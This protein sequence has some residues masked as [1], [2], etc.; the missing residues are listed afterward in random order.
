MQPD[1]TQNS[2]DFDNF[3]AWVHYNRKPIAIGGT[4]LVVVLA[5]FALYGWKKN[6]DELNANAAIF[7]LPSLIGAGEQTE[8][9]RAED[10]EKIASAYPD[11]QSADRAEIIAAGLLFTNG[12]YAEAEKQF[13]KFSNENEGSPLQAEAALGIAASMEAQGKIPEATAKYQELINKY[14]GSN[15]VAPAKLTL[16]RLLETQNKPDEALRLYDDLMRSNNPYDPWAAEARERREMLIQKHPDL[17]KKPASGA[18]VP[19]A[20]PIVVNPPAA[21]ATNKSSAK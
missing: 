21:T 8:N 19:A 1:T 6:Q 17:A 3:M 16:A 15:V 10:F 2:M 20:N 5:A 4:I 7:A 14:S 11:T 18:L 12:K 9:A 13:T